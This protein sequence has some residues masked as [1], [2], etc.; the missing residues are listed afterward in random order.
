MLRTTLVTAVIAIA[1]CQP[2]TANVPASAAGS[3]PVTVAA[4][5]KPDLSTPDRALK[6]WWAALDHSKAE[7]DRLDRTVLQQHMGALVRPVAA[8]AT[9]ATRA[10]F[11]HA[12]ADSPAQ[13]PPENERSIQSVT[14]ETDTRAVALVTTRN[15]EPIPDGV[16]LTEFQREERERGGRYRYVLERDAGDWR[17]AEIWEWRD[18]SKKFE[19]VRKPERGPDG[20]RFSATPLM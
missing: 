10:S 2:P 14:V 15:V 13:K 17:I 11:E 20:W 6:S 3:G 1:G 8:L 4:F 19:Q 18:Y 12:L 9:G 16:R 7:A 5:P